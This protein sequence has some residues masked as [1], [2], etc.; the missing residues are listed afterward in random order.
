MAMRASAAAESD[1]GDAST[2]STEHRNSNLSPPMTANL[3]TTAT[4]SSSSNSSEDDPRRQ[5]RLLVQKALLACFADA[6]APAER[7]QLLRDAGRLTHCFARRL[8]LAPDDADNSEGGAGKDGD[9]GD[10]FALPSATVAPPRAYFAFREN[11]RMHLPIIEWSAFRGYSVALWVNVAFLPPDGLSDNSGATFSLFRFTNGSGTLGVEAS[12]ALDRD[13]LSDGRQS[14]LLTVSSCHPSDATKRS[15]ASI[16]SASAT[17]TGGSFATDWKRVQRRIQLVPGQWHLLVLAHSLHYVRKSKVTCYVDTALQFQDELV[18]P[19]GLVTASKCTLGGG[20]GTAVQ[21][22]SATMFQDELAKDM[23]AL[24]HAQGPRISSFHRCATA[25]PGHAAS[26]VFGDLD[27][28][29]AAASPLALPYSDLFAAYC[30]LQV[31]FCYAAHDLAHADYSGLGV[32]WLSEGTVADSAARWVAMESTTGVSAEI[33]QRSARLGKSVQKVVYPDSQAAWHSVLGVASLPALLH[34]LLTGYERVCSAAEELSAPDSSSSSSASLSDVLENI[35]VDFL[36]I[37]KGL[38]LNSAS[39][40]QEVLQRY[41]LH[42]LCHVLVKHQPRLRGVWTPRSLLVCVEMVKSLHAMLPSRQ[43]ELLSA[44]HPLQA[45]IWTTNPLFASGVRAL[46]LDYRL[47]TATDFKTQSIFNH[48]LYSLVCEHPRLFNDLQAVPKVLEILREF[49]SDALSGADSK[50]PQQQPEQPPASSTSITSDKKKDSEWKQHCVHTLVEVME[51]CLTNQ[52]VFVHEV[53]DEELMETTFARPT[54]ATPSSSGGTGGAASGSAAGVGGSFSP[55]TLHRQHG[56]VF[57]IN[58]ENIVWSDQTDAVN[59]SEQAFPPTSAAAPAPSAVQVRFALV[60]NVRAIVRFLLTSQ[61]AAVSRSVLLLLRRLAVSF[62]DMRFALISSNI[63]DCLLFLMRPPEAGDQVRGAQLSVAMACVPLFIYLVDWL[64]SIE[65]RTVWCGLEEHL[66]LILNGEGSFSVG[67]L[68]LMMEFYFNPPLLLGVQQSVLM[69]DPSKKDSVLFPIAASPSKAASTAHDSGI[70]VADDALAGASAGNSTDLSGSISGVD[71]WV[72]RAS[73]FSGKRLSLSW[74]KRLAVVKLAALRNIVIS[75]SRADVLS[76]SSSSSSSLSSRVDER[77]SNAGALVAEMFDE[78]VSGIISLPLRGVLPYL[79][80][81]LGK[82][83]ASFREKVLMDIN[84]KLKTDAHAQQQLLLTKRE[85]AEALLELSIA[86]S[87][88]VDDA[89]EAASAHHDPNDDLDQHRDA[90][91]YG[92][93]YSF[94]A[95]K[96]GEDLVLDTIVSLLC[97]AMHNPR[98]WRSFTDLILALSSIRIKYDRQ[99]AGSVA[100]SAPVLSAP[101]RVGQ[102]ELYRESLDWLSRVAGIVLQRMARSRTILS[103]ALAENLQKLLYLVHETLLALPLRQAS[104]HSGKTAAT[105]SA[106]G[107]VGWAWSDAQLFLLNAVLDICARLIQ[108][109]HKLHRIGLLPGLQILQRALPFVAGAEM[110]ERVIG[111][112]VSFFQQEMGVVAA[113]KVYDHIPTRDVF[114]GAMVCLRRA[115][116]VQDDEEILGQLRVLALRITTSGSFVDELQAAGVTVQALGLMSEAD[117]TLVA[118]DALALAINET[119]MHE[120]EED[121]DLVPHFPAAKDLRNARRRFSLHADNNSSSSSSSDALEKASGEYQTQFVDEAEQLLWAA[122]EVEENRTMASLRELAERDARLVRSHA[123]ARALRKRAWTEKLWV[124]HEFAFRSQHEFSALATAA[125]DVL[126][127]LRRRRVFRIGLY[128][129][130]HPGR[131]RRT[132]DVDLNSARIVDEEHADAAVES[133]DAGAT[134][135]RRRQFSLPLELAHGLDYEVAHQSPVNSPNSRVN[136]SLL[137]RVGRVVAEQRGGEIQDITSDASESEPS[138]ALEEDE[139]AGDSVEEGAGPKTLNAQS[140]TSSVSLQLTYDH[141]A[142]AAASGDDE[143]KTPTPSVETSPGHLRAMLP[144]LKPIRSQFD[145]ER[146][147]ESGLDPGEGVAVAADDQLVARAACRRVIPEGVVS[148]MLYLCNEALSFEPTPPSTS[149]SAEEGGGGGAEP[150][151]TS[152]SS[153]DEAA[154]GLH[155]CWRWPYHHVVAVYLRRYRLRDSALEIFLRNGSSHFLD[156]PLAARHQRNELARLLYSF[157]PRSVPKQWPGRGVPNLSATTKAWQSRQISNFEYLMALNTFAGRSFNDLTQYPV[158]PWVLS[159]YDSDALDL[160]DPRNFRD[161]SKPMGALN[162][163]RLDEYWERYNSF[164]DPV[165]PKFLYGSHYSTCAGVVL[166]FLFRLQPFAELQR[167]MQGGGFDLPDRLFYSVKETWDMCN[168]Q[169]SEVK[170]LTPEFFCDANF[171]RNVNRFPLGKRHDRQVVNDVQLPP[172]AATPEEFVRINRAALESELVSQ[173]LHEWLDLIFGFKQRG[174]AALRAHNVFYYLTYYGVVDLDR[175]DDPFLKESMELQ[176][177]HFGQCP[178]QLFG[179]PHPKRST[180]AFTRRTPAL[181]PRTATAAATNGAAGSG[182]GKAG[183]AS[184]VTSPI[185]PGSA[186]TTGGSGAAANVA[187]PLS[188]S[189]QDFTPLAQENRRN[190]SASVDV[191]P[192]VQCAVRLIKIL[193][194]RIVTVNELGVVDMYN[195]KLV[196]KPQPPLPPRAASTFSGSVSEAPAGHDG[197]VGVDGRISPSGRSVAGSLVVD[198]RGATPKI[199]RAFFP[200][201]PSQTPGAAARTPVGTPHEI[202]SPPAGAAPSSADDSASKSQSPQCPWLVEV[203]RED[204]PFD[205]IPRIPIHE[206][207]VSDSDSDASAGSFPVAFSS[208]GRVVLSGGG[209]GGMLHLR[210]VDLDSGQIVGKASV[211]GHAD[212]VT[213]L[214]LDR[215][216]YST[217]PNQQDEEELVVSGSNDGTLALWRLSRVK[218]DLLFRLPRVS[219]CPILVLRG[220]SAAVRDCC[221]ST[222]LGLVVSCSERV[223]MVHYLHGEGQVAFE[224]EPP[225][226]PDGGT[227]VFRKVRLSMKGY[228]LALSRVTTRAT[229]GAIHGA[230][231]AKSVCQVFNLSGVLLHAHSF[232]ADDISDVKLSAEGDLVF[233]VVEP[234]MLRICRLDDFVVVQ[235][236][237]SPEHVASPV[238]ATCFGPSEAVILIASGH[239][240]GTLVL[241]LLPEADGSVSFLASVRKMLGVSSKLKMVKGTVQQAQ[242]LAMTT[243]GS[244]KAVTST[245]RDIAGEALGEAKSMVRG[246]L[247][248]L[249]RQSQG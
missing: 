183:I 61:D 77:D 129:T 95:S 102:S 112:L 72:Q 228:I 211:T 193:P 59:D 28:V 76:R 36:W 66:R 130:P 242:N 184:V 237:A 116:L 158:F 151:A 221:V 13:G 208:N 39:N 207:P 113:L 161:L 229:G 190:W 12:L 215:L 4:S 47:W 169:M 149:T 56:G 147:F 172:W 153:A 49:Y 206:A 227:T 173:H 170:E 19:S 118:L 34:Y 104:V 98:G 138:K 245:A 87:C 175:I 22:A 177:A 45:S 117:A 7:A 230:R 247:T 179:A 226:C 128:E 125:P 52:S 214:S 176:I 178:M 121:A 146:E 236:Y 123:D 2:A 111:V 133:E 74:E 21:L 97:V 75:A 88:H 199:D 160:S 50:R 73:Q 219:S 180:V 40:Q 115:L 122:L 188:L 43:R 232:N 27:G 243:L 68:E 200:E 100:S 248:Y 195:W 99:M 16:R 124:K 18:Y 163:A 53:K 212:A 62:L 187:R 14:V 41:V 244:A 144:T 143:E 198:T 67:F 154:P 38:L 150:S 26:S 83:S 46:L 91:G 92:R 31:V 241:Q 145:A 152:S 222:F 239:S 60:R 174:K 51:V 58:L 9:D 127:A 23:V 29:A 6:L 107:V 204:S 233:L 209:R 139:H 44:N 11:G 235:E 132:L 159:N 197:A 5:A 240:D 80:V 167:R 35:L 141:H 20:T 165:I 106:S 231:Q 33:Q 162:P 108:S 134:A 105:A 171:L 246:F 168:S 131:M 140:E 137:E 37:A 30:R 70:V 54:A 101:E 8:L 3:D 109:T 203:F 86:C 194:D 148:G 65:G 218:Q 24:L 10:A 82:S 186:R 119:E 89:S 93:A 126:R 192:V 249:Q 166:F 202:V 213:C 196:P 225:T 210:L 201:S 57:S 136:G 185:A 42:V 94:D 135:V 110:M 17:A 205:F 114:L 216:T 78:G 79:P 156:F 55:Y 217:A 71:E 120:R 15:A 220:H 103:R 84:V 69:N 64:E 189:F 181:T 32:E 142:S 182:A 238:S 1:A 25:P 90:R 224:F 96:T 223:G 157:L 85:W 155:R 164:D 48:Q 63:M 234:K 191:K 81:L